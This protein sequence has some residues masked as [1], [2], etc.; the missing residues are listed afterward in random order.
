RAV[1]AAE[2]SPMRGR[3]AGLSYLAVEHAHALDVLRVRE[4]VERL[5]LSQ[6]ES[7]IDEQAQVAGQRGRVTRHVDETPRPRHQDRLDDRRLQADTGRVYNDDIGLRVQAGQQI[8][9]V[10]DAAL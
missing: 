8:L 9:D 2:P 3:C 1:P 10:A 7:V 5:H 4:H 6:C